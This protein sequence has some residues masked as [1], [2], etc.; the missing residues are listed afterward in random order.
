MFLG[1]ITIFVFYTTFSPSALTQSSVLSAQNDITSTNDFLLSGEVILA[2]EMI[3]S[4]EII[5]P[6]DPFVISVGGASTSSVKKIIFNNKEVEFFEYEGKVAALAGTDLGDKPGQY[7]VKVEFFDGNVVENNVVLTPR[8]KI[9]EPLG[10]PEKLGGNTPE[11]QK[12]LVTSISSE[13]DTLRAIQTSDEKF[14][15]EPFVFPVENPFVTDTYG[16]ARQTGA[17]TIPHKGTDLRAQEG[18]PVKAMNRGVVRLVRSFSSYGNTIVIDHG[19]GLMTLYLHLKQFNVKEGDI[20]EKNEV[21]GLSGSTGY[22]L[23]PHLHLSIKIN[24]I[25]I[26]PMKFMDLFGEK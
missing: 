19:K 20:V 15:V 17:Y 6:G 4:P 18:T 13:A 11:S 10:I 2:P 21:I 16:Y 22:A 1:V 24:T 5:L 25:S 26:D 3:I 23:A 12:N 7:S 14:W 8:L 9:E